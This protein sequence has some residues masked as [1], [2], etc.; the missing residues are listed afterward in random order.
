MMNPLRFLS[1][2]RSALEEHPTA[3]SS[4]PARV[5]LAEEDPQTRDLV[6][7]ALRQ[8]GYEVIEGDAL[9]LQRHVDELSTSAREVGPVDLFICDLRGRSPAGLASLAAL[10]RIDWVSPIILC[11]SGGDEKLYREA[12]RLGAASILDTPI[13]LETLRHEVRDLVPPI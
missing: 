6:A 7:R 3:L 2:S 4:R 13:D 8:E 11:G 12:A 9:T 5:L 1:R 10:R